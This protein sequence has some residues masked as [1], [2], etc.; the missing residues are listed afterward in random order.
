MVVADASRPVAE[1]FADA[2][3]PSHA[4]TR[5]TARLHLFALAVDGVPDLHVEE[6]MFAC[7]DAL[8]GAPGGG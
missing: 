6:A 3:A 4:P 7:V 2:V 5:H 8:G 1:L